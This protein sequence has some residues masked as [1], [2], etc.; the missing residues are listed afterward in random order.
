MPGGGAALLLVKSLALAAVDCA[1]VFIAFAAAPG[2]HIGNFPWALLN[3]LVVLVFAD[4]TVLLYPYLKRRYGASYARGWCLATGGYYL[5][6]MVLTPL[7]YWRT[8][9]PL[10]TAMVGGALA[11]YAAAVAAIL[12]TRNKRRRRDTQVN[13]GVIALRTC[14]EFAAPFGRS[15]MPVV[16]ELEAAIASRVSAASRRVQA[17]CAAFS[18][19]DFQAAV[20][21]LLE[22]AELLKSREKQLLS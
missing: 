12:L 5:L 17:L 10:F 21:E 22:I 9:G 15:D 6:T 4:T 2:F 11:L 14:W 19:P 13:G 3:L 16:L 8:P 1:S 20:H 18:E 7:F